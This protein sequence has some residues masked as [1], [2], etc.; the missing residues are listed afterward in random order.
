MYLGKIVEMTSKEK[1]FQKPLHPY[2]EGLVS[3]VP[4]VDPTLL[5]TKKRII[6]EGDMPSQ[7]NPLSGCRFHPRCPYAQEVCKTDSPPLVEVQP[8]HQVAC[9]FPLI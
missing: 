7:T 8:E 6:L 5:D 1:L 3:V 2:T 9:H 4:I